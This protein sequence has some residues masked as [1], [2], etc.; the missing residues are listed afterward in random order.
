MYF[1]LLD[2]TTLYV[3]ASTVWL[4]KIDINASRIQKFSNT[5]FFYFFL[6]Y[7]AAICCL[8]NE[9]SKHQTDAKLT[10]P[11]LK[12]RVL[13][14]LVKKNFS[15]IQYNN[16]FGSSNSRLIEIVPVKSA[17]IKVLT[18]VSRFTIFS[19]NSLRIKPLFLSIAHRRSLPFSI[20]ISQKR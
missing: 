1:S 19:A 6:L 7:I 3:F 5:S 12:L 8:S 20:V 15:F 4:L 9:A 17:L 16:Q 13:V 14:V 18:D 11:A 10:N 2:C